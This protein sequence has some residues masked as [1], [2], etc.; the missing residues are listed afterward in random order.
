VVRVRVW[1]QGHKGC[2]GPPTY[3]SI[4]T[5]A[6]KVVHNNLGKHTGNSILFIWLQKVFV[7]PHFCITKLSLNRVTKSRVL[8]L[9]PLKQN[10]IPRFL[11]L[12]VTGAETRLELGLIGGSSNSPVILWVASKTCFCRRCRSSSFAEVD[13]WRVDVAESILSRPRWDIFKVSGVRLPS[14]PEKI[15]RELEGFQLA[16]E[17][18]KS[19][20]LS[21]SFCWLGVV[22]PFV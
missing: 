22:A 15:L 18:L 7:G 6:N 1:S 9:F 4:H 3:S 12:V 5:L 13:G 11:S 2:V 19:W 20:G 8:Q 21:G 16:N 10:L 17:V 14:M